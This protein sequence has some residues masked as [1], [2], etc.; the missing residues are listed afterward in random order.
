V[1]MDTELR[2]RYDATL[3]QHV[4]TGEPPASST[5]FSE[6]VESRTSR[7]QSDAVAFVRRMVSARLTE[8]AV[9]AGGTT[10]KVAGFDWVFVFKGARPL[11]RKPEPSVRV[12][13]RIVPIVDAAAIADAWPFV[14]RLSTEDETLCLMMLGSGMA[15]ARDLSVA[16]TDLRKKTRRAGPVVVPV[17]VRDWAALL[18]AETPAPI[19]VLLDWLRSRD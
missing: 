10:L 7:D 11:F 4:T 6:P 16:V 8:A 12:V 2:Q 1:L 9:A 15:P 17:D 14:V 5:P 3:Q 18:P 19:R 13:V